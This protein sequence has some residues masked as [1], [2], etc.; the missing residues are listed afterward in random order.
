MR[1]SKQTTSLQL[2]FS[3]GSNSHLLKYVLLNTVEC[4]HTKSYLNGSH[5]DTF[6]S[7]V[8]IGSLLLNIFCERMTRHTPGDF[9]IRKSMTKDLMGAL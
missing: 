9:V 8:D 6:T 7:C 4:D 3:E 5:M 1:R 2:Y